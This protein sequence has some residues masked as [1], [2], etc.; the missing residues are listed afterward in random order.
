MG[1]ARR[2]RCG[3]QA[4]VEQECLFVFFFQAEDGIRDVAV[5]GVQTCALPISPPGRLTGW[6]ACSPGAGSRAAPT[7][8]CGPGSCG[9]AGSPTPALPGS[10]ATRPTPG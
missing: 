1:L 6:P 7:A 8:G 2:L 4:C 9:G 5:T 3:M 10:C